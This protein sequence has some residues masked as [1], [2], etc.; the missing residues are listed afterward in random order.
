MQIDFNRFLCVY[1]ELNN[2]FLAFGKLR[3]S[4]NI[5]LLND[6]GDINKYI[7][8]EYIIKLNVLHFMTLAIIF[9]LMYEII[10]YISLVPAL[11]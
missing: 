5:F 9:D 10:Y 11:A 2:D 8:F 4:K 7:H 1:N 6:D 3:F